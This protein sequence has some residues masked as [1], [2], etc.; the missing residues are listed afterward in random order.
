MPFWRFPDA[1]R[2][3]WEIPFINDSVLYFTELKPKGKGRREN[4]RG[5]A[6]RSS[7]PSIPSS[8]SSLAVIPRRSAAICHLSYGSLFVLNIFV[9]DLRWLSCNYVMVT[10]RV[11]R[12][13]MSWSYPRNNFMEKD[14]MFL[15][16]EDDLDNIG[17]GS[18]SVGDN[19]VRSSSQQLAT[20]TP[21]GRAQSRLLE[22]ERHVVINGRI[23]MTIA[24]R[25]EKPIS[26][27]VVRFSQ[28]IG[29]CVQ[30]IFFVH[31]LKWAN[32]GRE[33]I[34]RLFVLDFNDQAMNKFVEHQMLTT[35]KEFRVDYH[36]HFKK[37]NDPEEARTNPP[38][39]WSNHRRTRLLDRSSLTI[40]VAGPSHFY[41]DNTSSLR[42]KGSRSIVWNCFGKHTF[43]LGRS[44][45]RAQ[46]MHI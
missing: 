12:A 39:H 15:E 42:E 35:F 43:E 6:V 22:L 31:Y 5:F 1:T 8:L 30:K 38:T 4:R 27:H 18:S 29:V 21:R 19:T 17:G 34:E 20:P 40:I 37:Y 24:P 13:I 9:V 45:R 28:A 10:S 11:W 44:C 26:P 16:F 32:V 36:R 3:R 46:R 23:P 14:A 41:N 25:A 33:Y 7:P 2:L